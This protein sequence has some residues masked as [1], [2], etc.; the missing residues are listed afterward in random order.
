MTVE[1]GLIIAGKYRLVAPIA[2]GGMGAVWRARH[3]TL[4]TEVAVK[5]MTAA[6][7]TMDS[8]LERFKR[9]ARAAAQLKSPNV[10]Q[11]HDYGIH[12]DIPYIVMELLEGEDLGAHLA[13]EGTL[14]LARAASIL[15]PAAKALRLAHDAG[16]VHR[17][18]KPANIFIAR[19]AG[20]EVVKVLDFGIAKEKDQKLASIETSNNALLGSPLYMS[21]EQTRGSAVDHRSDLWSLAVVLL[22]MIT[23][24]VPFSGASLGDVFVKICTGPIPPPSQMGLF[25]PGLDAFF[26]R[27]LHRDPAARFTTAS[28][29][30]SAFD[31]IVRPVELG[32]GVTA[33][34]ELPP[35]TATAVTN[36]AGS[37]T[38]LRGRE[39]DT[40]A[41]SSAHAASLTSPEPTKRA[42]VMVM[43]LLAVGAVVG[44]GAFFLNATRTG[45]LEVGSAA[46]P[47]TASAGATAAHV[48]ATNVVSVVSAADTTSA[49][50]AASA[51]AS[52]TASANPTAS[53]VAVRRGNPAPLKTSPTNASP[54]VNTQEKPSH[55][56]IF[57]LPNSV[58]K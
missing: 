51:A 32:A 38:P 11:I 7:A 20:D 37:N 54:A 55:D 33:R 45:D 27:A 25:S 58:K 34:V 57:G 35:S 8:A 41:A 19:I 14:S 1:A 26:E 18:L 49:S 22:E 31:G 28:E 13:R 53:A 52:A 9:E 2:T 17:D 40:L 42:R 12:E 3:E 39:A 15:R 46:T 21:P 50:A 43:G 48:R 16:L 47:D 36:N 29:M 6:A 56:P 30:A 5:V 10:V 44:G 4:E 24:D 23:G